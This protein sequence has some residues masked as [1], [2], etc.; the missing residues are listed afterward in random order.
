MMFRVLLPVAFSLSLVLA[1]ACSSD[2]PKPKPTTPLPT[3]ALQATS[4]ALTSA[5][6]PT[7][8]VTP[9]PP[10]PTP[11]PRLQG[12]VTRPQLTVADRTIVL[13]APATGVDLRR[14][15]PEGNRNTTVLHDIRNGRRIELGEG[16][17]GSFSP[18]G[19]KMVWA[20]APASATQAAEVWLMDLRTLEK[21]SMGSGT[22]PGFFDNDTLSDRYP[23]PQ[24]VLIDIQTGARRPLTTSDVYVPPPGLVYI[25]ELNDITAIA[26]LDS[27]Y[28][29]T[30]VDLVT[31]AE[32]SQV[33]LR[34][35]ATN[36]WTLDGDTLLLAA[37][38]E[39]LDPGDQAAYRPSKLL[40]SLYTYSVSRRTLTFV[41]TI[42]VIGRCW[43]VAGND[44][45]VVWLNG[46]PW[47]DAH[48]LMVYDRRSSRTTEL[49]SDLVR[50]G[51]MGFL[52]NGLLHAS[53]YGWDIGPSLV[54]LETFRYFAILPQPANWTQDLRFA[55]TG[56]VGGK[57]GGCL[58]LR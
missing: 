43:Q 3:S 18:D 11:P 39:V 50:L 46:L 9:V 33:I 37:P 49:T 54:D 35:D 17:R 44:R 28:S 19:T 45:Y 4:M 12:V 40:S 31:K 16:S 13:P 42:Q 20:S 34:T 6:V 30:A 5:Q 57:D 52:R 25:P 1:A 24:D 38:P 10:T 56:S 26:T 2:Y 29:V 21:R 47:E 58:A 27:T 15:D 48:P 23:Y 14:S 41:A 22:Q 51:S 36:L 8:T 53:G 32:P 55:S 7:S